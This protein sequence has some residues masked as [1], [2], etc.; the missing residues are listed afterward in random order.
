MAKGAH[1]YFIL[2]QKRSSNNFLHKH[3][4][5]SFKSDPKIFYEIAKESP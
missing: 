5:E 1:E 4:K 3:Q 2:M